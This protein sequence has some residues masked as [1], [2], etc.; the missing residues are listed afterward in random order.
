[1]V[2][3]G[4]AQIVEFEPEIRVTTD[5]RRAEFS[6]NTQSAF[7]VDSQGVL[8][9]VYYV[10][11]ESLSPP[12]SQ[13]LHQEIRDGIVSPPARVDRGS[14]GGGRHPSLAIDAHNAVHVV[15][16]D[17]RHCTATG[18]WIDNVEI[19]YNHKSLGGSFATE[20]LR[21]TT[22]QADHLGD[23]GYLPQILS[24]PDGRLHVVWYDFHTNGNN[25]D[26]YLLSSNVNGEFDLQKDIDAYRL[27]SIEERDN[28]TSFWTPALSF[29][30][31]HL[32][33]LWG[34]Q[35]G[36]SGFNTLLSRTVSTDHTLGE[37]ETV[38]E[39]AG[40]FLDPPRVASDQR[41]NIGIVYVVLD[42]IRFGVVFHYRAVGN[43]WSAPVRIDNAEHSA[44]QPD[45]AFDSGG[46]AHIV[47][48]EDVGGIY[49]AN[50]AVVD[51]RNG[52]VLS[53]QIVSSEEADAR[54]PAIALDP[55][56]DRIHIAWIDAREEGIRSVYS[57][58]EARTNIRLWQMH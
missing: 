18:N 46:N 41:G 52:V 13:I 12:L 55:A 33:V 58:R 2:G 44:S 35:K 54:T 4:T 25:A 21:L 20:D 56:N 23:N 5:D 30:G 47:W 15:W 14:V 40:R 9:L 11:G 38:A 53:R 10:S 3:R 39:S 6:R 29:F 32:F 19:Y 34:Y 28:E 26:I 37:I 51:P 42:G 50:F 1:L 36:Y 17:Q 48:Q 8:H 45:L 49:T 22:T 57:I 43:D 27:T 16:H 7:A 31:N 24:A